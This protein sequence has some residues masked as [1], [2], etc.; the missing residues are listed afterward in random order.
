[1]ADEETSC[2]GTGGRYGSY[3]LSPSICGASLG[4]GTGGG[5]ILGISPDFLNCFAV[6]LDGG[7]GGTSRGADTVG[8]GGGPLPGGS[9]LSF[10]LEAVGSTIVS[11]SRLESRA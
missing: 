8:R 5:A 3:S 4:G 7:N 9:A 10:S 11:S 6:W 1:M 2:S